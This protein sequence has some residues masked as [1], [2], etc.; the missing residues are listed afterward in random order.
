M[1]DKKAVI[2][3]SIIALIIVGTILGIRI[4]N[5]NKYEYQEADEIEITKNASSNVAQES[6]DTNSSVEESNKRN[7]SENII[8]EKQIT[9]NTISNTNS[10]NI[11]PEDN[12]TKNTTS[13]TSTSKNNST[14]NTNS[15]EKDPEKLAISLAKEK[16]GKKNSNVYFDVEDKN[17]KKGIYTIVVRDSSTTVEMVTYKVD[18][19]KKTVTE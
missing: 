17:E 2:I 12:S 4:K 11:T 15:I 19:N 9:E 8:E 16:W 1:V 5:L 6:E 18:I 10:E 7:D 13:N 14:S 3:V